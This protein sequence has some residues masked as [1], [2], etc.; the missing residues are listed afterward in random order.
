MARARPKQGREGQF[1]IGIYLH[2]TDGEES[3]FFFMIWG[4][5]E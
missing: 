5:V 4:K 2:L 3:R 1:R